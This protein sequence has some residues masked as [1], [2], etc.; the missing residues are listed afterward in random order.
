M[1]K[2]SAAGNQPATGKGFIVHMGRNNNDSASKLVKIKF[3]H[4]I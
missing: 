3:L 4:E 1:G 2:P